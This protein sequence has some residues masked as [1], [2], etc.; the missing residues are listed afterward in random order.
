MHPNIPVVI[1]GL[2]DDWKVASKWVCDSDGNEVPNLEYLRDRFGDDHVPV[3][4]QLRNGFTATRPVQREMNVSEYADWW[5]DHHEHL[6]QEDSHGD[7]S[8][9]ES[10]GSDQSLLY[11]KDWKFVASHSTYDAYEWPILFRDDWLNQAMGS[12]YRFVYLGPKGTSTVLHADVLRSFSWSTNVCGRKRWYLVPPKYTYLLRDCFGMKLASHLHAD[13]HDGMAVFFP[14]LK[15]ARR[16]AIEIRQEAGETIFVPSKWHHTVENLMD[17]LSINHNWLNRANIKYSWDY[18][19]SELNALQKGKV[20]GQQLSSE[21][22]ASNPNSKDSSQVGDDF[23]LLWHVLSKK[24]RN[25]LSEVSASGVNEHMV[26]D[27]EAILLILSEMNC[28]LEDGSILGF[29]QRSDWNMPDL[30]ASIRAFLFNK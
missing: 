27:M 4:E 17:T 30:I 7:V 15:E 2:T 26:M 22:V 19:K 28:M 21:T 18:L 8:S 3:H 11:L 20:N 5:I 16:H 13:T 14:G 1:Q 25:H 6:Q 9:G 10:D 29:V 23:I 24:I 12:A